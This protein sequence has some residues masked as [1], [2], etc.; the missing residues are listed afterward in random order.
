[1]SKLSLNRKVVNLSD[2]CREIFSEFSSAAEQKGI[3]KRTVEIHVS[4][5]SSILHKACV[6]RRTQL[7]YKLLNSTK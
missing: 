6:E 3:S 2:F 4:H 5:V 1:M 7:S